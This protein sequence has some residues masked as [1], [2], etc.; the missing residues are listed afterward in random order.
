MVAESRR[1]APLLACL[2][3]EVGGLRKHTVVY[4]NID[5]SERHLALASEQGYVWLVDMAT[6]KLLKEFGVRVEKVEWSERGGRES[7]VSDIRGQGKL[8]SKTGES[9][10]HISRSIILC[11]VFSVNGG[12]LKIN[13]S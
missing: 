4:S 12:G 13:A 1:L 7:V 2:P 3:V 6:S 9:R 5:V 11:C 8:L 10:C